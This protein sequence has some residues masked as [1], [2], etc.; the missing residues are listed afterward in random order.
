MMM[1]SCWKL[2]VDKKG[3][4][5]LVRFKLYAEA[6]YTFG[7]RQLKRGTVVV[8]LTNLAEQGFLKLL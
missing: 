7:M 6:D 3:L 2:L 5:F 4:L 8:G 1:V